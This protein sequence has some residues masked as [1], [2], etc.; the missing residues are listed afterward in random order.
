MQKQDS[1]LK[2]TPALINKAGYP[3]WDKAWVNVPPGSNGISIE[4]G[5]LPRDTTVVFIPLTM[6]NVTSA[7][8]TVAINLF[9]ARDTA[10]NIVY[11][12]HYSLYGFDTTKKWS[13][14]NIFNM[15]A[16]FDKELF[17]TDSFFV[18]DG[19]IFGVDENDTLKVKRVND[20]RSEN[21]NGQPV[22][23]FWDMDCEI[24][25]VYIPCGPTTTIRMVPED[26]IIVP[27]CYYDYGSFQ[28]CNPIWVQTGPLP[29]S[30]GGGGFDPGPLIYPSGGGG[31]G[32]GGGTPGGLED[33]PNIPVC[34]AL[35]RMSTEDE[36]PGPSCPIPW[37]PIPSPAA[38]NPNNYDTVGV[39]NSI[40]QKYPCI[41]SL[42]DSL[43]DLNWLG[44]IA[45]SE[46]FEDSAYMHL[47]IDTSTTNTQ[48]LQPSAETKIAP[49]F[50]LDVD[51][52]THFSATIELNGWYLRN[53]SI[54]YI[55]SILIHEA[56]HATFRLRLGQYE[57]WLNAGLG[58]IDSNFMKAHYGM[59]WEYFNQPSAPTQN[60][61]HIIM[62][63]EFVNLF[64][65]LG[66]PF[67]NQAAPTVLRDSVLRAFGRMSL[68]ETSVWKTLPNM[69]IDT[70]K[71]LQ[72]NATSRESL[73]GTFPLGNCGNFTTHFVDSL[74][75]R[76]NCN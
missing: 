45:G 28:I 70:C 15:F 37:V 76:P 2:F 75:L 41:A 9:S 67:Y 54:E 62:G 44:Q 14:R 32:S 8:M 31:G 22:T 26:I 40:M 46:V 47:T 63:T 57:A 5:E 71:I 73:I 65:Q 13:A 69:G 72:I 36:Q 68:Y 56:M 33:L 48:N 34:P 3:R 4:G 59:Y 18:Y 24:Y 7:V 58:S 50:V 49:N 23:D 6:G 53:A 11:P 17:E 1:T 10:Y 51:G 29:P 74:R 21:G 43:S 61:E 39:A 66:S 52:Q 30:G 42:I 27:G 35:E 38:F 16:V 19:R 55:V 60:Q 20:S 64:V 25:N 12:Q